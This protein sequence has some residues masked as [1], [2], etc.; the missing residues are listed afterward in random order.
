MGIENLLKFLNPYFHKRNI[1]EFKGKKIGIDGYVW[2]HKSL[3]GNN[4][5]MA[6]DEDPN[7]FLIFLKKKTEK[8]LEWGLIPIFVFDG[9]R[10]PIK[11]KTESKREEARTR[12]FEKAELLLTDNNILGAK[13]EYIKSIDITPEMAYK[14]ILILDELKVEYF[15]SPYES[16]AQLAYLS[17]TK[18]I[19]IV[20]TE[21]SDLIAYRCCRLIYKLDLNTGKCSYIKYYR[22][23]IRNEKSKFYK[24]GYEKFLDFCILSGC[25]YFKVPGISANTAYKLILKYESYENIYDKKISKEYIDS[26]T[27]ARDAFTKHIIYCPFKNMQISMNI[28]TIDPP[29]YLGFI[30]ND[31]ISNLLVKGYINPINHK[32]FND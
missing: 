17:R 32:L 1:Q 7:S 13:L 21:D 26:Y 16:D 23:I 8:F 19:D 14:F 2:L 20:C 18:Y 12:Q 25:D 31:L 15:V 4:L 10:L 29:S 5:K 3:Y 9:D 27:K 11:G 24:W 30:E 28:E 6:F 22:D